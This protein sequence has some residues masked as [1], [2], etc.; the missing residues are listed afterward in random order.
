MATVSLDDPNVAQPIKGGHPVVLSETPGEVRFARRRLDADRD[1]ILAAAVP[2][3]STRV[4]ANGCARAPLDGICVIDVGQVLAGPTAARGN[5]EYG[6]HFIKINS[7]EEGQLGMHIYSNPGKR[8]MLLNLK[9][10]VGQDIPRRLIE[11]VALFTRTL[12]GGVSERLHSRE[13]DALANPA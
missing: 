11:G 12:P 10:V 1:A 4:A 6:A 3:P 13:L 8:S 7:A 9:T 5:P 2:R